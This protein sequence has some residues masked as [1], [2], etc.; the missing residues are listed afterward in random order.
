MRARLPETTLL[1][2]IVLAA[3]LALTFYSARS[4]RPPEASA[5]YTFGH[6]PTVVLVHGL[7]SRIEHWLP[8][9]RHLASSYRVVLAELPG[10]GETPLNEPLT[11]ARAAAS[12]EAAIARE[13][14]GPVTL[15]GHS[16]GGLVAAQV[17]LDEP[18]R[19]HA[20]VLVETALRPAMSDLER[21][22]MQVQL[23]GNYAGLVRGS[24]LSFGRDSAQGESLA[25]QAAALDPEMMKAWIHLALTT[26]LSQPVANLR[27]PVTAVLSDRSW[28]V[29]EAWSSTAA[30][31]GYL[32]IAN[33]TPVRLEGC[34]HFVMLDRPADLARV[35][36][37]AAESP[38]TIAAVPA[39]HSP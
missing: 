8:T 3:V 7:G 19:V 11:L 13:G 24:Y 22:A 33:L 1:T 31:L 16:I 4:S 18:D 21:R 23:E 36:E 9:A 5:S 28:P 35:I 34:G 37:R 32:R 10:H 30:D 29:G 14:H 27:V 12:I 6:G 26:D 39:S 38:G 17:A 20:L 15:V 25:D 2:G